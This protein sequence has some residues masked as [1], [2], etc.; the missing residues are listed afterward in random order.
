MTV[1]QYLKLSSAKLKSAG[2]KSARL[3]TLILFEDVLSINRA[4]LLAEPEFEITKAQQRKLNNLLNKRLDHT[5]LAYLRGSTEFYGTTFFV[6]NHVLVPRPESETIIDLLIEISKDDVFRQRT[7]RIVD[8]GTGCGALGITAKQNVANSEVELIDNDKNALKV[9]KINV[10]KLT[11]GVNL[12]CSDLLSQAGKKYDIVLA[13]LPYV[14]DQHC[15]NSE[16]KHEPHQAIYSGKTGLEHYIR[17]L[18]QVKKLKKPP[19]YLLF[20][21]FPSQH[22]DLVDLAKKSGYRLYKTDHFVVVLKLK[23]TD[24]Y[25]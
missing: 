21:A 6:N 17:L 14:P 10:D 8:V 4:R 13:N 11:P 22:A 5:P 1:D 12:I 18:A 7:I 16:A 19:L 3:D 2:I 20:E 25:Y 24:K 15:I 23:N 9:A